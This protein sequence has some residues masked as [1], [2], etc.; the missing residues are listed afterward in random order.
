MVRLRRTV[1]RSGS[2][3]PG[4]GAREHRP[5]RSVPPPGGPPEPGHGPCPYGRTAREQRAAALVDAVRLRLAESGAA[6]T[7]GSVAAALRATRP[8]LGGDEVLDTVRSLR[9]ELVGAGPLDRLLAAPDVTDVLVNGPDEVWVDRGGGLQRTTGVRFADAEAVR[10]L[11][12]RLATAAGRRLDDARPWVDARLPDG[13][14]LHAVLPPIAA[15]CTH[16]SLRVC[17]PRPFTLDELVAGG[18]LPPEGAELLA[19]IVRARLSLLVSGGTGSGKTTLLSAL[20]GLVGPDERIVL[21]EDSAELQPAHPHVV[22]LQSRPPNQEGLGEFTLRDLVRQA[23]RMRPDRLVIGEV[24]G[25]E[26]S[27]LLAALNTGHEGGCGTVHANTAAD[28]P[29]RLEALGALAGLDRTALHGQLR[30][31][32]DVV[33]HLVRDPGSGRRRVA[34]IHTLAGAGDGSAVTTPAVAFPA[35]GGLSP[36]AGW[37]RLVGLLA[38]RGVSLGRGRP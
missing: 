30:A 26:V 4:G 28:V 29:V 37:E 17:R 33:V 21:A 23:L 31:A 16:I 12:H 1:L 22:R 9:A 36:G 32:L 13:T 3:G 27:D 38:A 2:P 35:S 15:G 6:P 8:P 14:R 24:R 25:P 5:L 34:E 10:R 18:S 11:A 7:A 20:L 19:G